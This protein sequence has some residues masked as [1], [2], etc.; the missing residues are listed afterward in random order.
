MNLANRR[1]LFLNFAEAH[2]FDPLDSN[3]WYT[4]TK[5]QFL[6]FKV[7]KLNL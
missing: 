5:T 4:I 1:D 2:E 3:K 7:F 6:A